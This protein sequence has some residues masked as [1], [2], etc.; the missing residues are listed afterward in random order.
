MSKTVASLRAE[1]A[2]IR[3]GFVSL[4]QNFE[5]QVATFRTALAHSEQELKKLGTQPASAQRDHYMVIYRLRALA[6]QRSIEMLEILMTLDPRNENATRIHQTRPPKLQAL[7][8]EIRYL[9][10]EYSVVNYRPLMTVVRKALAGGTGQL[11]GTGSLRGTGS[12]QPG[13]GSGPLAQR[14][15]TTGSLQGTPRATGTGPVQGQP[16]RATT[17]PMQA[18]A[19]RPGTAPL[20]ATGQ[21]PQATTGQLKGTGPLPEGTGNLGVEPAEGTSQRLMRQG[22]PRAAQDPAQRK[23]LETL[24]VQF[25]EV[26]DALALL[27][28]D[29]PGEATVPFVEIA[30]PLNKV[31]GK[32]YYMKRTLDQLG[33]LGRALAFEVEGADPELQEFLSKNTKSAQAGSGG[34]ANRLKS[35]LGF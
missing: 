12:L 3:S 16:P 20:P 31:N 24:L 25:Q 8:N 10:L 15:G 2:E 30:E 35:F 4:K 1:L 33:G 29:N 7:N 17:G 32:I 26:E 11:D 9:S 13:A 14:R 27:R 19:R 22:L 34:I 18:Q 28:G 21:L 6:A 5:R 23:L